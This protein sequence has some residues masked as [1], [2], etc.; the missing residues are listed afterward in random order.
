MIGSHA[1]TDHRFN[2]GATAPGGKGEGMRTYSYVRMVVDGRPTQE[3][4]IFREGNTFSVF[5]F[6]ANVFT[7]SHSKVEEFIEGWKRKHNELVKFLEATGS[8]VNYEQTI[9]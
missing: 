2:P 9:G 1:T 5:E 6:D 7:G 4:E 8:T 3:L